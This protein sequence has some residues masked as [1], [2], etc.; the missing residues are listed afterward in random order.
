MTTFTSLVV[1]LSVF[2]LTSNAFDVPTSA[3]ETVTVSE[4]ISADWEHL[5][6]T[7][8][9]GCDVYQNIESRGSK[10]CTD[11][12]RDFTIDGEDA[13]ESAYLQNSYC[14]CSSLDDVESVHDVS[15][16]LQARLIYNSYQGKT[17]WTVEDVRIFAQNQV[18]LV[19]AVSGR[20][21]KFRV[22]TFRLFLFPHSFRF[23]RIKPSATLMRAVTASREALPCMKAPRRSSSARV[24]PLCRAST[25]TAAARHALTRAST[26]LAPIALCLAGK[27]VGRIHFHWEFPHILRVLAKKFVALV[28]KE[29]S[30]GIYN[31]CLHNF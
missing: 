16:C 11:E 18:H 22:L 24:K 8:T 3:T 21:L 28:D 4:D 13:D 12:C 6:S 23:V 31:I 19:P 25:S 20:I 1:L 27:I 2:S 17:E 10:I 30:A 7:S 26:T 15:Y 14:G 5:P 29:V 9:S